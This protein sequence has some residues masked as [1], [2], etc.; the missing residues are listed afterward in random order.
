MTPMLAISIATLILAFLAALY[1]V[2]EFLRPIGLPLEQLAQLREQ[3]DQAIRAGADRARG[4]STEQARG[5][6]QEISE[7]I[8]GFQTS[9]MEAFRALGDP[10]QEQ[11]R[12]LD[13]TVSAGLR[14]TEERSVAIA[15][16]IEEEQLRLATAAIEA[17]NILRTQIDARLG[18]F[19]ETSA[20][21]ARE[22][23]EEV[24]GSMQRVQE[25]MSV[26]LRAS[27]QR[28]LEIGK[29]VEEGL[30]KL[31]TSAN[32]SQSALRTQ[33]ETRLEAFGD[34]SSNAARDLR[35]EI[36]AATKR[37]QEVVTGT[38]ETRLTELT[39]TTANHGQGLRAELNTGLQAISAAVSETL[40]LISQ[41]QKERLDGLDVKVHSLIEQQGKAQDTLRQTVETRLDVLRNENSQKLDDMR[42]TVDEKL[43][44]TL[45]SRITESF[46]IV[47][48]HLENVHK[49][50]GEMQTLA[51]GVGDLKKVLSNVKARGTWGEIQLGNLLEQFLSPDQYIHNAQIRE[52]SQERVE[53][54]IRM[55]GRGDEKECLIPIDAKFPQE[56]Y[57]RLVAA[58]DA[59]D[60]V[61]VE[62]AASALESR[63]KGFAKSIRE[64]YICSPLTT[65]FAILFLPTESLYAEVLRRPG[66]F[67]YLQRESHVLLAG[68]TTLAAMLNAFQMGFRSLAIQT[69]SA[70]V[71]QVLGAVRT[72]FAKHGDVVETLRNQLGRAV[73][74]IDKLGTRTRVMT[75]ALKDVDA[76]P[77]EKATALLALATDAVAEEPI[78]NEADN[79]A[80]VE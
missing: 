46:R 18:Q 37:L 59:G 1:A 31:A 27:E 40:Q 47:S 45:E 24:G 17:Q 16:R 36:G 70:E 58:A 56:D 19:G 22:L 79:E 39:Q 76:L 9:V 43:Q 25:S 14:A 10:L 67:E 15:Q 54:A 28:S 4:E 69:R 8:R 52:G 74:T 13:R 71:W 7:N 62:A 30:L 80:T 21:A 42:R 3:V 65:E 68:P 41:Q 61:R 2:R 20:A 72:E 48:Q 6:R 35:D 5:L 57:T 55:P 32:A 34:R 23:R 66:I 33:I 73:N 29:A 50:L 12:A 44:S 53:Y 77:D 11:M 49:G 64:K 26:G 60:S 51:A 63:I 75:R 78:E 38:L